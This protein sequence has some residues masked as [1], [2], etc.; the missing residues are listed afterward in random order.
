MLIKKNTDFHL[1]PSFHLASSVIKAVKM[2]GEKKLE[3]INE[4]GLRLVSQCREALSLPFEEQV[5]LDDQALT[6]ERERKKH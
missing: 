4:I 2:V 6:G 1:S 3:E 5:R